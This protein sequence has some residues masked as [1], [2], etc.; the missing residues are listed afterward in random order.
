VLEIRIH[1]D[2]PAQSS[3]LLNGSNPALPRII[4]AI[5]PLILPKLREENER[6][7][8]KSVAKKKGV[9]DVVNGGIVA[10]HYPPHR[11][12]QCRGR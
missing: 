4:A 11:S 8:S 10:I 9:K 12:H 3:W 6:A 1:L 2:N 5:R 7:R